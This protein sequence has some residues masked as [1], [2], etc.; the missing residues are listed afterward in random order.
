MTQITLSDLPKSFQVLLIEA[1]QTGES[2]TITQNNQP[3]AIISPVSKSQ[4]AA[5][6]SAQESGQI[7][8]DIVEPTSDWLSY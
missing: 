7:V 3:I 4:R 2:L 6:G 1:L 5:F 8:G